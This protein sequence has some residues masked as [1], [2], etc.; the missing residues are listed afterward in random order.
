MGTKV[1]G[2]L[3]FQ[4]LL[5]MGGMRCGHLR[6]PAMRCLEGEWA[7]TTMVLQGTGGGTRQGRVQE[8]DEGVSMGWIGRQGQSPS[9]LNKGRTLEQSK[10]R[11]IRLSKCDE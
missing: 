6:Q 11:S 10:V 1:L 9:F 2:N 7:A 5:Q 3:P 4:N 8:D